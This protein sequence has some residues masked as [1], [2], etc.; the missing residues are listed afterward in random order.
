MTACLGMYA[1][2]HVP[3]QLLPLAAAHRAQC[4]RLERGIRRVNVRRRRRECSTGRPDRFRTGGDRMVVYEAGRTAGLFLRRDLS[5]GYRRCLRAAVVAFRSLQ[6]QE[7]GGKNNQANQE[8]NE[9]SLMMEL[10]SQKAGVYIE[11]E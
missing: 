2:L 3:L 9:S 8:E 1:R 5:L 10:S 11:A 6:H 4:R 7:H